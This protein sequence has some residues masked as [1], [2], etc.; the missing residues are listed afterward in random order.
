MYINQ[1]TKTSSH[2][3]HNIHYQI[4]VVSCLRKD[5]FWSSDGDVV[6]VENLL[7]QNFIVV[8]KEWVESVRNNL[9]RIKSEQKGLRYLIIT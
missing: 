8:M 2:S 9:R 4:N 6:S 3:A 1:Y 7:P 5:I